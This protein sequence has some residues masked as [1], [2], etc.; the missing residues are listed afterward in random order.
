MITDQEHIK[1]TNEALNKA[2][3]YILIA[4]KKNDEDS[5]GAC[6]AVHLKGRNQRDAAVKGL[7]MAL[8]NITD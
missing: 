4:L 7:V 8:K 1:S 5:F 2:D 6:L 3:G